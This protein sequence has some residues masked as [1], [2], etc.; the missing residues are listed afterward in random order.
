MANKYNSYG[1]E[2]RPMKK[3]VKI[4]P[5][6]RGVG[7]AFMILIPIMSYAAMQ[8]FMEQNDINGWFPITPDMLVKPTDLL[9]PYVTDARFYVMA[10]VFIIFMILMF[11]IFTMLTFLIT[12]A[13]GVMPNKDPYYVP[14][15]NLKKRRR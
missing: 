7:F 11:A 2:R 5:V 12:G 4:H 13:A 9:G 8:V 10:V 1:S 14:P 6:W 3:E 15:P